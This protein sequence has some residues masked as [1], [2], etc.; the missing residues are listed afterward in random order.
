MKKSNKPEWWFYDIE[1]RDWDV[2]ICIVAVNA[3][4]HS[5][6]F[7]NDAWN[8]PD[9]NRRRV[10]SDRALEHFRMWAEQDKKV[11][12][13]HA[14]GLYDHLLVWNATGLP[15]EAVLTGSSVLRAKSANVTWR[16]SM[17]RWLCSLEKVGK[18][19]GLHKD[20]DIDR[21][22]LERYAMQ[23]IVRYC[24]RDAEVLCKGWVTEDEWLAQF[25][26]KA[27]T[28]GGAAVRLLQALDPKTW[29]QLAKHP[30][31][32][33]MIAG[34]PEDTE[35]M[36]EWAQDGTEMEVNLSPLNFIRG[37]RTETRRI[38]RVKGPIYVYDLHSSY[39]SQYG[40]GPIPIGCEADPSTDL[41][42][43]GW[44]DF[45]TWRTPTA[46]PG[47]NFTALELGL[48][49]WGKGKLMAPMTWEMAQYLARMGGKPQRMG[50]GFKGTAMCKDFAA[51][52]VQTLY[53]IK[54]GG[55]P[56]SFFAKVT[57][58][59]LH[60]RLGMNPDREKLVLKDGFQDDANGRPQFDAAAYD[61]VLTFMPN[62]PSQQPLAAATVLCRAR[63]TWIQ[64]VRALEKNGF[65]VFYGDTD[66]IH[67]DCPPGRFEKIN[68]LSDAMG[69]WGLEG[70]WSDAVYLGPK[71]YA[72]FDEIT[73]KSKLTAK[74]MPVR[75][76]RIEGGKTVPVMTWQTYLDASDVL[77]NPEG[78]PLTRSGLARFKS[79]HMGQAQ[80]LTRRLRPT[81][82]GR[83][84]LSDGSL[85]YL[86]Q[87]EEP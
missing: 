49:G 39:P 79:P 78:I 3:R 47:Y 6:S 22:H 85:E 67:T 82:T 50:L 21:A 42:A 7:V 38:G 1:A 72:L 62:S 41:D 70:T 56:E 33:R 68:P 40:K 61:T 74:G 37:G 43:V 13:A 86:T 46:C 18:A 75:E 9:V 12:V 16:D 27:N 10:G 60:G 24:L 48:G 69:D 19:V 14:G 34:L 45:V 77:T 58:N 57:L 20:T 15:H 4:G 73:D 51:Q 87:G 83:R 35:E 31:S 11:L 8:D 71:A 54:E 84:I 64:A 36:P 76:T 30:V 81:H 25:N 44:V 80:A 66:S 29:V 63:L 55:G 52:F 65:Q 5:L 28:S 59:S 23:D 26:V 17:P 2:V 53:E 32:R